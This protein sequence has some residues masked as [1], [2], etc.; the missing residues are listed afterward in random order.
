DCF[1]ML[2]A[3][4]YSLLI[5]YDFVYTKKTEIISSCNYIFKKLTGHEIPSGLK[6]DFSKLSSEICGLHNCSKD[7]ITLNTQKNA[8]SNLWALFHELGHACYQ[9]LEESHRNYGYEEFAMEEAAAYLFMLAG[10]QEIKKTNVSLGKDMEVYSS[11]NR[12]YFLKEY[13]NRQEESHAD[14]WALVDALLNFF[15]GNI[16]KSYNYLSTKNELNQLN[17]PILDYYHNLEEEIIVD[18]KQ[19]TIAKEEIVKKINNLEKQYILMLKNL[20]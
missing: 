3:Q 18:E 2:D 1:N 20:Q 9:G 12:F 14:G 8:F 4:A 10:I 17:A 19:L 16:S 5:K 7:S 13:E 6:I 11:N 15:N